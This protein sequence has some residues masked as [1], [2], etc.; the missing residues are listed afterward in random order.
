V[1]GGMLN[2]LSKLPSEPDPSV[3]WEFI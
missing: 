1:Y 3:Y 2:N